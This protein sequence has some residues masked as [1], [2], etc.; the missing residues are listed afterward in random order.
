[1]SF[2]VGIVGWSTDLT[3][4]VYRDI[5]G[6]HLILLV[7]T[8]IISFTM[9]SRIERMSV[10]TAI[11]LFLV[12]SALFGFNVSLFMYAY[13]IESIL[14]VFLVTALYFGALAAYGFLTKSN[15]S[16]LRPILLFGLVFLIVF[17]FLSLFIP[18]LM[19]FDRLISMG[20]IAIFLA[21]TAYD[22]QRIKDYY[23]YY[24]GYPDM[25]AKASIFSAL[26]LY[27][28]FLNLFVRLLS[29]LGRRRS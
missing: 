21:Y 19:A 13:Q 10:G 26:Q 5:P 15:L 18:G 4:V 8:L 6:F 16:F 25:L 27:L 11:T 29:I 12:F 1:M 7:G 24:A 20:A 14:L 17:Y 9:V 22:T 3:W 23:N 28:D 2:G